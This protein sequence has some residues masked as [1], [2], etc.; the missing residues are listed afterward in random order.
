[1]FD[2][3][4]CIVMFMSFFSLSASMSTNIYNSKKEIGVLRATGLKKCRI[5]LLFFY[6][7]LILVVSASV[8]GVMIGC[9][10]GWVVQLQFNLIAKQH[11]EFVFPWQQFIICVLIALIS[12][13]LSTWTAARHLANRQ[14]ASIFRMV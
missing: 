10:M 2:V 3:L 4:V 14:I 6:E 1:M 8:L 13:F 11:V 12:A 7:A 9:A 5:S